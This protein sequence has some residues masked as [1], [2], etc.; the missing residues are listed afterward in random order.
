MKKLNTSQEASKINLACELYIECK[1]SSKQSWVF[2]TET[3]PQSYL[4]FIIH[5]MVEDIFSLGTP[6]MAP[7]KKITGQKTHVNIFSKIPLRYK[8]LN[9]KIALSQQNVFNDK[10]EFYEGQMQLLK[11]LSHQNEEEKTKHVNVKFPVKVI[12]IIV[13]DGYIFE[14]Y[15]DYKGELNTPQLEYTR[16]LTHGLPNQRFPALV[17]IVT[18]NYFPK[19]IKLIENEMQTIKK[20]W[21]HYLFHIPVLIILTA[22]IINYRTNRT[23]E[24]RRNFMLKFYRIRSI[25]HNCEGTNVK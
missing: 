13:F 8:E 1:K 9:Y 7:L 15:Y 4:E 19:Y 2:Y 22:R 11:A 14:C 23:I 24:H 21:V 16:Y 3:L 18:L 12:P 20:E 25:K 17:D 5:R 6:I 10:E